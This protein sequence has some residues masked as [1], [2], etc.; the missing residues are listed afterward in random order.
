MSR[1][2][3]ASPDNGRRGKGSRNCYAWIEVKSSFPAVRLYL[4]GGPGLWKRDQQAPGTREL[5]ARVQE[6]ERKG[7]LHSTGT[8]PRPKMSQFWNSVDIAVVPSL[9][10][11]FGLVALEALACGVPVVA[12]AAG[13]LKEIV[14]DGQCGLLVPPGDAASLTRALRLL[15]SDESLRLRLSAGARVRA[16]NFSIQHR[17]R[18]F[19]DLL[20]TETE[21][22]A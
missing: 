16:R 15:L 7:L 20:L 8:I 11:S 13:G 22:A 5:E 1:C 17:S 14:V 21:R 3:W 10:E 9:T 2:E 19:L 6:M 12:A 18:M 4:A